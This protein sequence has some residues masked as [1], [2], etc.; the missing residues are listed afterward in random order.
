[1]TRE[2]VIKKWDRKHHAAL[3]AVLSFVDNDNPVILFPK[4]DY[5]RIV[6]PQIFK[7]FGFYYAGPVYST[8]EFPITKESKKKIAFYKYI[9]NSQST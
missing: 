6:T 1:M 8:E 7:D 4:K 2:E 9:R 3:H 5:R